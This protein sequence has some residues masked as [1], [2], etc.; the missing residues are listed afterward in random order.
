MN[1]TY[2]VSWEI[3]VGSVSVFSS[4]L[5]GCLLLSRIE[6]RLADVGR[7]A[8]LARHAAAQ[9]HQFVTCN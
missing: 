2:F 5:C 1:D 9:T 7:V 6:F 8:V 4:V 3:R